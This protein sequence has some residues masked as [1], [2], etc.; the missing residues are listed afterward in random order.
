MNSTRTA[1]RIHSW[2]GLGTGVLMVMFALTGAYLV[3]GAEFDRLF[4][5]A[6][7]VRPVPTHPVAIDTV[8]AAARAKFADHHIGLMSFPLE[9]YSPYVASLR[10]IMPDGEFVRYQVYVDAGTGEAFGH[11]V[12]NDYLTS[13]I[14]RLHEGL[15][16]PER[17][18]QPLVAVLGIVLALIGLTGLWVYRH[19]LGDALRW[20]KSTQRLGRLHAHLGVWSLLFAVLLGITGTVLNFSSLLIVCRA[21]PVPQLGSEWSVLDRLPSVDAM[22]AESQRVFPD[23][24]VHGIYFPSKPGEPFKVGG[25]VPG[26]HVLGKSSYVAFEVQRVPKVRAIFDAR[27]APLSRRLLLMTNSLHYGDFWDDWSKGLYVAASLGLAFL[28][29]SGVWIGLR[30]WN[31]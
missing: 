25:Y 13:W 16:L 9:P 29:G 27:K 18:G 15:W 10:K 30:R 21:A 14:L 6:I 8:L 3:Y 20:R 1:F 28:A 23:L 31:A 19:K 17:W 4:N 24:E 12:S 5:P 11:R 7:R 22:V 26:A 2:L